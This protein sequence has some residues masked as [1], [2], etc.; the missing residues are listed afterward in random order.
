MK[1]NTTS[2]QILMVQLASQAALPSL[3]NSGPQLP[4][5]WVTLTI[6]SSRDLG[7]VAPVQGF[8]SVGPINKD[9]DLAVAL[10]LGIT[11]N[12]FYENNILGFP[13]YEQSFI[14]LSERI[15]GKNAPLSAMVL[16]VFADAY[17]NVQNAIWDSLV[18]LDRND[19]NDLPFYITGMGPGAPIAQI[20]LLDFKEGNLGPNSQH[21]PEKLAE[22]YTFSAPAFTN[23]D[24]QS[25]YNSLIK[26][27]AM[28]AQ[29][30]VWAATPSIK[31]DFFPINEGFYPLGTI[32]Y[33]EGL[34]LPKYNV[35]WWNR[36]DVYY[37]EQ[38]GGET[39]KNIP[40][41]VSFS[42]IP[43]DFSR[44]MAHSLSLMTAVTYQ[45]AQHPDARSEI[46]ITPYKFY[47]IIG[48]GTCFAAI[49]EGPGS[50]IVSFRGTVSFREYYTYNC[51]SIFAPVSFIEDARAQVHAGTAAIYDLPITTGGKK[52][53]LS[54]ALIEELKTIAPGKKLYLTGHDI[55][56]A[57]A[58]LAA[59]DYAMSKYGFDVTALYTFGSTL[60]SNFIFTNYFNDVV[61]A[62]SYQLQRLNDT[63]S[64]SIISLGY[65]S[66]DNP[67]TMKGQLQ[68]EESTF[69]SLA[70]YSKLLNPSG[71]SSI[72]QKDSDS[73]SI[74]P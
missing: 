59:M 63:S 4:G 11:W 72:S 13:T 21:P 42:N 12:A 41:P 44:D 1:D 7:I 33:I 66:L 17:T 19:Y 56:G 68:T 27:E 28:P 70:G 35:P 55:G 51:K 34:I 74:E 18:Y 14:P 5:G 45:L 3:I 50:V 64:N 37:L 36:S 6:F 20:C 69:H 32:Q 67:I 22:G 8:L 49:F 2:L 73:E 23:L 29:Y 65:F 38:L 9:G 43:E 16:P 48:E 71:S 15:M 47:K 46:V 26:N 10:S 53:T 54:A 30:A 57:V 61:G 62:H 58:S 40:I 39:R 25:Y 52:T 60:F 31:A 24:F